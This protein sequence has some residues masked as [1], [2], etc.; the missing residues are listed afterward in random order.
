M[1]QT[2]IKV[3]PKY[4]TETKYTHD[5]TEILRSVVVNVLD[6]DIEVIIIIIIIITSST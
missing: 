4:F 3:T 2:E 5:K 1:I 6:N